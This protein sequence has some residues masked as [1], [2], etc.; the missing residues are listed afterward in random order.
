MELIK[1]MDLVINEGEKLARFA[2]MFLR[3]P[4]V[5]KALNS[6]QVHLKEMQDAVET[7]MKEMDSLQGGIVEI[8]RVFAE[9]QE[10]LAALARE[11]A[12]VEKESKKKIADTERK[13]TLELEKIRKANNDAVESSIKLMKFEIEK[14]Q[15]AIAASQKAMV[16]RADGH[17]AAIKALDD[18]EQAAL[19]KVENAQRKLTALIDKIKA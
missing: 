6:A 4:E 16:E 19:K 10:K 7:K 8:N 2:K 5:L 3:V 12:N 15:K 18:E 17:A 1:D 11:V 14:H 13:E 9:K